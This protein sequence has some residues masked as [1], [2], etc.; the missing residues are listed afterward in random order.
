MATPKPR[1][2][3]DDSGEKTAVILDLAEY[4]RLLEEAE[5]LESIRA[6][7]AAKA[8]GDEAIPFEQ[9]VSEIERK[10]K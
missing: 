6:Y 7:D 8:A 2:I 5:E 3:V 1:F 10:R 9:A 4:K